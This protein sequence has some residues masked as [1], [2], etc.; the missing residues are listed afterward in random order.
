VERGRLIA[1][2]GIDGAGTTTQASALV[3][4]LRSSGQAAHLT[5]EPSAGP[6]GTLLR[7]VLARRTRTLDPAATALLF[8]ADRVDHIRAEIEPCLV[9]G[10]HVVTDRYVYS[11]LA[12]Q[13]I[14]LDYDWVA[15][16]NRLASEPDVT[17]YVRIDPGLA[18]QR[19]EQRGSEDE[20]F[21]AIDLQRRISSKYDAI[22][23]STTVAGSWVLDPAGSGW[24]QPGSGVLRAGMPRCAIVDGA[25]PVD[26][27]QE[28]L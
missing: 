26:V 14:E 27:L 5:W 8:A 15:E 7:Q 23:G 12:Y 21:D 18:R 4:W 11:S 28:Q 9:Q 13:S 1:I 24:I 16:I 3:E 10:T 25:L 20:I 22:F 2:E 6:I 17:I 19:R